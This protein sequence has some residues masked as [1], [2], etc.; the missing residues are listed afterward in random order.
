MPKDSPE[1]NKERSRRLGAAA[2]SA[3]SLFAQ[4]CAERVAFSQAI[5]V[6][7]NS[8]GAEAGGL[9]YALPKT[10]VTVKAERAKDGT[11]TYT[12][13][14]S[15]VPDQ[16][17]RYR[18]RYA[19][20]WFSDDD[21]TFQV[22]RNGLLTSTKTSIKDRA[23]DIVV[24]L[25]KTAGAAAA[26]LGYAARQQRPPAVDSRM[27]PFSHVYELETFAAGPELK[28][29]ARITVDPSWLPAG[30]RLL[31]QG[32]NFSVCFRT[33]V[34]LRA[35]V[36]LP[37]QRQAS[38][39]SFLAINP[40]RTE[41]LDFR[42]AALVTRTN[43]ATFD[44][45]ILTSINIVKPSTAFELASLP[46]NMI[47]AFFSAIGELLTIRVTNQQAETSVLK[48]QVEQLKAVLELQTLLQKQQAGAQQSTGAAIG[49]GDSP[50]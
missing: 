48:S 10:I 23:G 20:S 47:K 2:L 45:G 46:Y 5:E 31:P 27:Y 40:Y 4:G 19:A 35:S 22:D 41:G 49:A 7:A 44:S 18:V 9:A 42:T 34:A 26:V 29:G 30:D 24:Q 37:G 1:V 21:L 38:E 43:S 25:A 13:T 36:G 3:L 17:A 33:P 15:I 16:T 6:S 28:D 14:P 39:F 50:K 32:C 11:V 8:A 12:V